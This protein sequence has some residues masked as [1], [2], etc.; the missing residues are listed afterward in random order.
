LVEA[1]D[2]LKNLTANARREFNG[3]MSDVDQGMAHWQPPGVANPIEDLY[4]HTVL[5][6]DRQVARLSG[7]TPLIEAWASRLNLG[8]DWRHTAEASRTIDTDVNVLKQYG[9]AVFG[10]VDAYLDGLKDSDLDQNVEG[11]RGPTALSGMLGTFFVTHVYEHTGEI[12]A[13]KGC[14]GAKGYATA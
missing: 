13:I 5:G 7:G 10:A 6:Q 3:A 11:F 9:E 1:L 2:L 14:Q 8:S 12:S 4:L